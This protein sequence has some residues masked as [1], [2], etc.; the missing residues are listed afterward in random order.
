MFE[1]IAYSPA[2]EYRHINN[3][4]QDAINQIQAVAPNAIVRIEEM[5]TY[6]P[7]TGEEVFETNL[8]AQP[9]GQEYSPQY[10]VNQDQIND[11]VLMI[12]KTD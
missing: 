6:L 2:P 4:P 3:L 8:I 9:W 12:V 5:R 10:C 1:S 11:L 7:E